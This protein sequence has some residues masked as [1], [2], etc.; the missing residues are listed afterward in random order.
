M[1]DDF[2]SKMMQEY[3]DLPLRD[4]IF[5]ALRRAIVMGRL[6]AGERI[7]ELSLSKEMGVSRTP[8][9]DAFR[10]LEAEGLIVMSHYKGVVVSGISEKQMHDVLEVRRTLEGLSVSLACQR[11]DEETIAALEMAALE[12]EQKISMITEDNITKEEANALV[13]ADEKFHDIILKSARNDKLTMIMQGLLDQVYR[14][15]FELLK[16]KESHPGLVIEHRKIVEA[17]KNGDGDSAVA[18]MQEHID[19]QAEY[20]VLLIKNDA[21]R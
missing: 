8:I 18:V 13:E 6:K 12:F 3:S 4:Q 14:Y 11:M 10:M 9:R 20:I 1:K 16:I 2:Y 19:R 17:V 7:Y 15:R 21:V 5:Y